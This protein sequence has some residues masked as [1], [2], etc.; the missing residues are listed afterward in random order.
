MGGFIYGYYFKGGIKLTASKITSY[1]QYMGTAAEMAALTGMLIGDRFITKDTTP[2]KEYICTGLAW[3]VL[4]SDISV[5]GSNPTIAS[6]VIANGASLSGVI[7]AR[8]KRLARV[9]IPATWTAANLT[10]QSSVDGTNFN[11]LYDEYGAEVSVMATVGKVA[12]L[13]SNAIPLSDLMYLKIRSGTTGT[14]VNQGAD[15]T[16]TIV[17]A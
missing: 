11:D 1:K 8:G 9:L 2:V 16:L 6:L 7:D 12:A 15:R 3:V 17:L 5:S 14:P 13:S 4:T 10:F